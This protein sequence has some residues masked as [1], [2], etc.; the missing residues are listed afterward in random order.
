MKKLLAL[1]V[2]ALGLSTSAFASDTATVTINGEVRNQ[3]CVVD[4]NNS[5]LVVKL[6]PIRIK[7]LSDKA[8]KIKDFTV[9]F[10][11]CDSTYQNRAI[12]VAFDHEHANITDKGNLKNILTGARAS[13]GVQLQ[14]LQTDKSV[15]NLKDPESAKSAL[16]PEATLDNGKAEFTFQVGYVKEEG[17]QPT[18]GFITSSIPLTLKYY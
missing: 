18:A 8:N 2:I 17:A 14:L 6:D 3:T 1:S 13:S 16:V 7:D 5:D 12:Y 11:E 4:T 9:R 10:K 15:I